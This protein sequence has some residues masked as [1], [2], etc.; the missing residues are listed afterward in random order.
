M[1]EDWS[2]RRSGPRRPLISFVP[3]RIGPHSGRLLDMSDIGLRFEL[4][5][6]AGAELRAAT[7]VFLG[8]SS[9]AVPIT[10]V[11]TSHEGDGPWICGALVAE[12]GRADWHAFLAT[13]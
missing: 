4:D 11:W 5:A 1:M 13:V 8:R 10:V 3:I 2:D 9:T 12:H 7:T 6:P